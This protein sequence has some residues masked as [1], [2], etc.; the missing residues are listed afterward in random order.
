ML[1]FLLRARLVRRLERR[2]LLETARD[3]TDRRATMVRPTEAGQST[4]TAVM[5]KRRSLLVDAL[6]ETSIA[7]TQETEASLQELVAAL[8]PFA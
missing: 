8:E 2:G 4:L 3:E 1:L 5:R 7:R 6:A